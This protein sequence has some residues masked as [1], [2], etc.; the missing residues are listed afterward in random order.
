PCRRALLLFV[1]AAGGGVDGP[2]EHV[3]VEVVLVGRGEGD[4]ALAPAVE[5]PALGEL[6]EELVVLQQHAPLPRPHQ[7]PRLRVVHGDPVVEV[8]EQHHPA[9]KIDN[10]DGD[11]SCG[12]GG[13][14]R[15]NGVDGKGSGSATYSW[16]R[17]FLGNGNSSGAGDAAAVVR[18][19]KV[20]L[21]R[22]SAASALRSC[23]SPSLPPEARWQQTKQKL[24]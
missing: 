21:E 13:G 18:R 15:N 5:A 1:A 2:V 9:A 3:G 10:D 23:A 11:V 20:V 12:G 7:Q 8:A 17:I 14:A 6:E 24:V 4:E 19:R 22:M 16:S